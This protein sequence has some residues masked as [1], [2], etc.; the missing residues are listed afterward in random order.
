[1]NK[2]HT[3]KLQW[4]VATIQLFEEI[5]NGIGA[6]GE[7]QAVKIPLNITLQLLRQVAQRAT[8]L[9]DPQLNV[10]MLRLGLYDI[11]NPSEPNYNPKIVEKYIQI[12][13]VS[14]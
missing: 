11:S 4:K 5:I 12:L 9:N 6:H 3:Q 2:K 10:L 8:E 14:E 1:M 13:E 7:G